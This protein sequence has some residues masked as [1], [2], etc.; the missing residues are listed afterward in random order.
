MV[1][2]IPHWCQIREIWWTL[3]NLVELFFLH[4]LQVCH[5]SPYPLYPPH[6]CLRQIQRARGGG[7]RKVHRLQH[8]SVHSKMCWISSR[9]SYVNCPIPCQKAK[10]NF[11]TLFQQI[12]LSNYLFV[13]CPAKTQYEFPQDNRQYVYGAD[14]KRVSWNTFLMFFQTGE[15]QQCNEHGWLP[16]LLT[17]SAGIWGWARCVVNKACKVSQSQS[18]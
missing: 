9:L 17:L 18:L 6:S 5:V 4:L 12:G 15:L 8:I 16:R 13:W 10:Q 11:F 2:E 3:V 1:E 7:S 14:I